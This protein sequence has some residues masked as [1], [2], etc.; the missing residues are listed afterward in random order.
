MIPSNRRDIEYVSQQKLEVHKG[1]QTTRVTC[2][3]GA[4]DLFLDNNDA[5]LTGA[6]A[7]NG[8]WES[9]V[10]AW[11][12]QNI[13]EGD[14]YVD[15]GAN[16]GYYTFLADYLGAT[17][18]AFEPQP[19]YIGLMAQSAVFN[20]VNPTLFNTALSDSEGTVMLNLFG[21]M[22]GSA[23]IVG[24]G[25]DGR[26]LNVKTRTLDSISLP[27][28]NL[29]VKMDIEGAEELAWDGMTETLEYRKPTIILEY[30][31]GAYSEHFWDKMTEYGKVSLV[32]FD[33]YEELVTRQYAETRDDWITLTV[34]PR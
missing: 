31:P 15:L 28:G 34:R 29:I 21:A 26:H 3:G 33:G 6:I 12:V 1:E 19:N 27:A 9:W 8:F 5:S 22:D 10:T 18:Y 13:G 2:L 11:H 32:N 20:G 17:V 4:F 7:S 30:T 16:A 24:E 14:I 25:W 23:S